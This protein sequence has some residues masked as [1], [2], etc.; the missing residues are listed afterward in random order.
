MIAVARHFNVSPAEV[1]GEWSL[2]LFLDCLESMQA[3]AEIQARIND[4]AETAQ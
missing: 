1:E 2:G 4:A 3:E